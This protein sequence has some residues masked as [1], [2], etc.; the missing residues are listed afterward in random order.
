MKVCL[1]NYTFFYG[2]KVC[3]QCVNKRLCDELPPTE[4]FSET[5]FDGLWNLKR[6][7]AAAIPFIDY[8]YKN[9]KH[10]QSSD[11]LFRKI[12]EKNVKP[13][14][15]VIR[16][17]E[18]SVSMEELMTFDSEDVVKYLRERGITTCPIVK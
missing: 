12:T 2:N 3:G 18:I 16:H 5:D 10:L 14:E 15:L 8:E 4:S 7:Y 1:T 11:S 9:K 6:K 17:S 13:W